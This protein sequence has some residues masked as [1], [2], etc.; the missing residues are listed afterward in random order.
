MSTRLSI[1]VQCKSMSHS[2]YIRSYSPSFLTATRAQSLFAV[3][4]PGL[5]VCWAPQLRSPTG[6][7]RWLRDQRPC[8]TIGR[9]GLGR[10]G[11][12]ADCELWVMLRHSRRTTGRRPRPAA[13][14]TPPRGHRSAFCLL[15]SESISFQAAP[16][17][18]SDFPSARILRHGNRFELR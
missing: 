1:P 6:L 10:T 9:A 2:S 17:F 7:G 11:T 4:S 13:V 18:Y 8:I 3:P 15:R 14:A 16:R 5:G 12:G